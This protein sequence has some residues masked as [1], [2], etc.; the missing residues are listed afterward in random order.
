MLINGLMLWATS[1]C[2]VCVTVVFLLASMPGMPTTKYPLRSTASTT[3]ISTAFRFTTNATVDTR[4][5]LMFL[6]SP[7]L[8]EFVTSTAG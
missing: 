6:P 7:K 8:S 2:A 3:G 1:C 4:Q 5:P